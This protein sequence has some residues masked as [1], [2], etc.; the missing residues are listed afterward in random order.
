[1]IP[2]NGF[3]LAPMH[4]GFRRDDEWEGAGLS[5]RT[6]Y[7]PRTL[8]WQR[9]ASAGM[10][11]E[12]G[13]SMPLNP[14]TPFAIYTSKIPFLDLRSTTMNFETLMLKSLFAASLLVCALTLGAMI[15]SHATAPTI[16]TQHA[17]ATTAAG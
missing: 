11:W 15:A 3:A 8:T 13:F 14:G 5:G 1:M 10:A 4:D 12:C 2:S 6:S 7:R 9:C 16:A 17:P